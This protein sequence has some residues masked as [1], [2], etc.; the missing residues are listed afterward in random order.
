MSAAP[1]PSHAEIVIVGGGVI[2]CAIAYHLA[3][4]GKRDVLLLER[5]QLTHGTTWH[6]AGLVGQLRSSRNLT[7]LMQSSARL[8]RIL[9]R[10]TGQS[11]GWHGVGSLRIAASRARWDELKRSATAAK[12]FGF[13]LHLVSPAEAA[14]LYPLLEARDIEG[15]A[16]VPSDGFVDPASVTQALARGARNGGVTIRE[17][18]RVTGFAR[19]GDRI[20]AVRTELGDVGCDVAV[21]AAGMWGGEVG[22]MAGQSVAVCALEHQYAVTEKIAGLPADLPTL[23]DPDGRF[24][25]KPEVGGLAVGGWEDTTPSF[26]RGG[27][28]RDF[29]PELL[30]G[31]W[32][33]FAPIGEA[34]IA[35][36]PAFG[37][38]GIKSMINGPIPITADGEPIMGRMPN[39]ANLFIACGFT[40]GIAAAGGAGEAMANW[41]VDG[42]PGL[43]LFAFDVLRF[44]D[45]QAAPAFLYARA[46]ESYASYYAIAWPGHE[47][48]SARPART[49]PIYDLLVHAGAVHGSKFGWERPNWFARK[50]EP[51]GEAPDFARPSWFDAVGRE[52]RAVR[53]GVA[54]VDMSS[55]T[56]AE[57][58]GRGALAGLQR[59]AANDLDRAPG[60]ILYTQLLNVRGGIEADLTIT[61]L[62]QDRFYLV[63]GSAYGPHDLAHV[64]TH[65]PR[66]GG[67]EVSD[68]TTRFGVLNLC[69]PLSRDVLSAATDD[70]VSNVAFPY[71]RARWIH[72]GF[73]RVLALRVSYVGELGW[74]LHV[75]VDYMRHVYTRLHAI[76]ERH[77]LADVGYRAVSSLRLEKQY[78]Y[79]GAD[80]TPDETP[81]E[82]GLGWNVAWKKGDFVGKAA[83]ERQREAGVGR[84]LAWFMAPGEA[85]WHGGEA[86]V[87]DGRVIGLTTSAG[88]GYTLGRSLACG[89]VPADL[90][91]DAT[92]EIE[93][94]GERRVVERLPGPPYDPKGARLRA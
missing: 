82:A 53:D 43:N 89:Y 35:R 47:P 70:D 49:S 64:Q 81:L 42:D 87:V 86:I 20:T 84:R 41:I 28:P 71:M 91:V 14:R 63:T 23:R 90:A 13:E 6:A 31:D 78:L 30:P 4:R 79:W 77:G 22:A 61:R 19:R 94:F 15:A 16:W 62:T 36:I 66:D 7:R 17:G 46:V 27:I 29:G 68:A 72:I 57:I 33:R 58:T 80:I 74:E 8:Y 92:V 37:G 1:L 21:N 2:G 54:L 12:S 69:G 76:G 3:R 59:L 83:L 11:T 44:G 85:P 55:F 25:A 52:H 48:A 39:V 40:S 75:P 24:Y 45:V 32:E 9:E 51:R 65:M 50:G 88:F 67:V 10:E 18:V 93:A 56:K 60:T 26:G 73:A 34:A 5:R 38:T